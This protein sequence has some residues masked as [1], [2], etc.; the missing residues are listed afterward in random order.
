MRPRYLR[1]SFMPRYGHAMIRLRG[2]FYCLKAPWCAP[3]F[4]ERYRMGVRVIPLAF[5][6]RITI[7]QI[8]WDQP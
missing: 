6:W 4:S 5:G 7:K 3:L 8:D 2:K 1:W